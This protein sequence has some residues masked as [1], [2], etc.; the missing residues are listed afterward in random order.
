MKL[1]ISSSPHVREGTNVER[2]MWFVVIA[3]IP[4][5]IAS[6]VFFGI[7]AL[8][9]I[10]VSILTSVGVE[11]LIQKLAKKESTIK[12]GSAFLTGLLLGLVLPPTV[13]LWIPV[14]GAIFAVGIGKHVFGGLGYNI[15]NPA[16]AGRAFLVASWPALMTSWIRPD[17]ITG[18]TPLMVL[19]SEIGRITGEI[20]TYQ[21]LFFGNVGGC[22]GETS[23]LALL[24]GAGILFYKG[25]IGW[26][27]PVTY[28]G[29]VFLLSFLFGQDP[30]FHILAGG[31]MLGALFMAT[32]PVTSP[33]TKNGRL[34][35]GIGCGILTVIIRLYSGLPEGVMYSILLMNSLVPLIDRYTKPKPFGG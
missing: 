2:I 14:V 31:I 4:A 13:P 27:I 32:D 25:I 6:Y 21:D 3:L 29:T 34:I 11:F 33:I 26:R 22:L 8:L 20:T 18:A 16:L 15:F 30:I 35:F 1:S 24:I 23:A 9:I 19:K 7:K 12:D 28:L 5:V 17:G 10:F